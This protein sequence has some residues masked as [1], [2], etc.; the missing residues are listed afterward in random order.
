M[1]KQKQLGFAWGNFWIFLGFFQGG[2]P[3]FIGLSGHTTE[4]L[5]SR[6]LAMILGFLGV[7]SAYGILKRRK[8]GLY[9]AGLILLLKFVDGF[10]DLFAIPDMVKVLKGIGAIVVCSLW[11]VYFRNRWNWFK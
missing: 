11:C 2:L 4:I 1:T 3:L 5:P 10:A 9:L 7:G 6:S 8:Y